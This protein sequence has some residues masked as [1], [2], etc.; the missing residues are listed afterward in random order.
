MPLA[1]STEQVEL[2]Q[3]MA[4]PI[5]WSRRQAYLERIAELL[6]GRPI[7]NGDVLRVAQRVQVEMLGITV[8]EDD[9]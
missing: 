5:P 2:I 1:L 3:S 6:A 9:D 7:A 4:R 8:P